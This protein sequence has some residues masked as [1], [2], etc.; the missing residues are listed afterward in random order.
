M[1]GDALTTGTRQTKVGFLLR[2]SGGFIASGGP[3]VLS[4]S[5]VETAR[6]F[7]CSFGEADLQIRGHQMAGPSAWTAR[8]ILIQ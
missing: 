2:P 5:F 6:L 3:T 7:S 8:P 1:G 4:L